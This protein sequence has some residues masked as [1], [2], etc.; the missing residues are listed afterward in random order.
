M[1]PEHREPH[2][3]GNVW[4]SGLSS[5]RRLLVIHLILLGECGMNTK[6]NLQGTSCIG[7]LA[8]LVIAGGPA[9][10]LAQDGRS[11]PSG[12]SIGSVGNAVGG[13]VGGVGTALGGVSIGAGAR[14]GGIGAGAGARLDGRGLEAGAA[15][16]IGNAAAAGVGAGVTGADGI[17]V[18]AGARAGGG[19][20]VR[21]GLGAVVSGER[22]TGAGAGAAIGETAGPGA[23]AGLGIGVGMGTPGSPGP[24]GAGLPGRPTELG[25]EPGRMPVASAAA[26]AAPALAQVRSLNSGE[27]AALRLRCESVLR[28]ATQ[29]DAELVALCR[30]ISSL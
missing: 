28:A 18:G 21:A 26:A 17:I 15:T 10:S 5:W 20:G 12:G 13:V 29:Y 22:G 11:S 2:I 30:M 1:P 16:A 24:R 6:S 8:V 3:V 4:V 14:V 9:A 23:G 27:K 25:T 19:S 7:I